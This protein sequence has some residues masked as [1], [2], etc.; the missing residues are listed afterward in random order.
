MIRYIWLAFCCI[1]ILP[2]VAAQSTYEERDTVIIRAEDN[3]PPFSFTNSKGTPIG[4]S[5]ELVKEVMKRMERPYLIELSEW[6]PAIESLTSDEAD[7]VCNMAYSEQRDSIYHF[8]LA[9][10]YAKFNLIT[11]TNSSIRY[12]SDL[13]GKRIIVQKNSIGEQLLAAKRSGCVVVYSETPEAALM[14]L[15]AHEADGC[16]INSEV[17]DYY[18]GALELENIEVKQLS[19]GTLDNCFATNLA[20]DQL[21]RDVNKALLTIYHDGTYDTI[22]KKWLSPIPKNFWEKYGLLISLICMVFI[23]ILLASLLRNFYLLQKSAATITNS[24]K[25]LINAN[26]LLHKTMIELQQ[27]KERAEQSDKLK[28]A[29]LANMSHEIR[30]PLNCIIGF[31]G[32]VGEEITSEEKADYLKLINVN[33]EIL[34]NLINDILDLSKIEAGMLEFHYERFDLSLYFSELIQTYK[35]TLTNSAIEL[36]VSAPSEPLFICYDKKRYAQVLTNLMTNAFKYT[37]K[38]Y[39]KVGCELIG[40][41]IRTYVADSGIGIDEEKQGRL[42]G[43]FE[44]LDTFAQGTGLG[45]AIAKSIVEHDGGQIG[46]T[47]RKGEGSLFWFTIHSVS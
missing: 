31:S 14:S 10:S 9:Y 4:F 13:K 46:F 11:F 36:I 27:A 5:I 44:K 40:N 43:R 37:E 19:V 30:T 12:L 6:G 39:V 1:G 42:F 23:V 3:F 45:L 29:F 2:H 17:A 22:Y 8:S 28:S 15:N 35:Q 18:I 21:I 33:S 20:N 25:E 26:A 16:I 7:L 38:G 32:L 47:S 34:L 41:D 24:N